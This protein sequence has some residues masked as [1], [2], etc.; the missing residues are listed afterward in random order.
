MLRYLRALR[1]E[2]RFMLRTDLLKTCA[3]LLAVLIF[4]GSVT[5]V[6][7]MESEELYFDALGETYTANVETTKVVKDDFFINSSCKAYLDYQNVYYCFNEITYGNVTFGSFLVNNG[8]YVTK[9]KPIAEVRVDAETIDLEEL[10][11]TITLKEESYAEY[12]ET[13]NALLREYDRISKES[14]S[15]EERRTAKL[16]YD[17]LEVAFKREKDQRENELDSLYNTYNNYESIEPVTQITAPGDGYV[18]NMNRFRSGDRL[19]G[20][21]YLCAIVDPS[22]VRVVV[23]GG[24]DMLRYGM[25]VSVTQGSG[26]KTVSVPG[27][28]TT[29]KSTTLSASL[30]GYDD[31]IMLQGDPS[32]FDVS[33]DV[34]IKFKSVDMKNVLTVSKRAVY[35]DTKGKFVYLYRNGQSIKQYVLVGG[36]NP[37]TVYIVDGLNEGDTVVIK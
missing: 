35:E 31:V 23:S 5:P 3:L 14:A 37:D 22:E 17:R 13:N 32:V 33:Q 27:I 1:K 36:T 34:L 15:A 20:Y 21:T 12:S 29:N 10:M 4:A 26:A 30:I 7:A 11:N 2:T 24:S 16:L 6:G 18:Y 9:G 19:S 8:S 25:E 28:V